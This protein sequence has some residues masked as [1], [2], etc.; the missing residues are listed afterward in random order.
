MLTMASS[1]ATEQSIRSV[2]SSQC[3]WMDKVSKSPFLKVKI[4]SVRDSTPRPAW[5]ALGCFL[6]WVYPARGN[7]EGPET[8]TDFRSG[9]LLILK[10]LE[11][12]AMEED[13]GKAVRKCESENNSLALVVKGQ[14]TKITIF[15]QA[16]E[17]RD[18]LATELRK[19]IMPWCLIQRKAIEYAS[20]TTSPEI[21]SQEVSK[22]IQVNLKDRFLKPTHDVEN[23]NS[24]SNAE[25]APLSAEP[26]PEGFLRPPNVREKLAVF[27][28]F[29]DTL[30]AILLCFGS[31][32]VT[33]LKNSCNSGCSSGSPRLIMQESM[34]LYLF[35][36]TIFQV[37]L[38][39]SYLVWKVREANCGRQK[40]PYLTVRTLKY[41]E[42]LHRSMN[43]ILYPEVESDVLFEL[44]EQVLILLKIWRYFA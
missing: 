39:I 35:V 1:T 9:Y 33:A 30:K 16:E 41:N 20:R 22:G 27:Q 10:R 7:D 12:D 42:Q 3:E 17:E 21:F 25:L 28:F 24:T 36:F 6:Y 37:M 23:L 29:I 19:R 2:S 32:A 5:L 38:V 34:A 31:A 11:V 13:M 26:A 44:R 15:L 43:V 18:N 4:K 14:T 8:F 40:I